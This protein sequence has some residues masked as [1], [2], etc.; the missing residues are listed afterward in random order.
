MSATTINKNVH[1]GLTLIEL[2][3]V[4]AV[5]LV[6][7][8]LSL[9]AMKGLLRG[10][11]VS[12][13]SVTVKQYLQNAQIRALASGRPVAVFIDRVSM[14]DNGSGNPSQ[15]NFLATRLQFGEVFPAYE[16]DTENAVG[17]FD[18]VDY[19]SFSPVPTSRLVQ[20]GNTNDSSAD[21][22]ILIFPRLQQPL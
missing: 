6:L 15:Q 10:Q 11:K 3:L 8:T 9:S 17:T 16:G 18:S 1:R 21:R 2:L 5:M 7:A 14:V 12:Q 20:P 22:I 19:S 13:A 4:S